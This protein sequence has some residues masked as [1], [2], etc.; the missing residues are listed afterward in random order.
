MTSLSSDFCMALVVDA[1]KG[2]DC[3]EYGC[4]SGEVRL[5]LKQSVLV[6]ENAD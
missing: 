3:I 6:I 1:A 2:A 4:G 5:G